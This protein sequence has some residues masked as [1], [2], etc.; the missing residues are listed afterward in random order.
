MRAQIRHLLT[1]DINLDTFVPDEPDLF[2]RTSL[3]RSRGHTRRAPAA[4]DRSSAS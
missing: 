3:L 2:M 1:P 4:E